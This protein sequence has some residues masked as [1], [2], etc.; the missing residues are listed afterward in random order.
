MSEWSW[1]SC[2][3]SRPGRVGHEVTGTESEAWGSA[4]PGNSQLGRPARGHELTWGPG[5]GSGT[6]LV[7]ERGEDVAVREC[8]QTGCTRPWNLKGL[9]MPWTTRHFESLPI[10]PG[11]C[12]SPRLTTLARRA[13][14]KDIRGSPRSARA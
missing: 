13:G 4:T 1:I 14:L 9:L 7:R 6:G 10:L 2:T 3:R 5:P 8:P 11:G 12:S